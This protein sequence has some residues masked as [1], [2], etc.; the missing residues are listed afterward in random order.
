MVP[1]YPQLP[2]T[3]HP[4]STAG[5]KG[6]REMFA[7]FFLVHQGHFPS[8]SQRLAWGS[9]LKLRDWRWPV[10]LRLKGQEVNFL[11]GACVEPEC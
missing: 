10:G 7:R 3:L 5:L 9:H 4:S 1:G 2:G 6:H 8:C 11:A